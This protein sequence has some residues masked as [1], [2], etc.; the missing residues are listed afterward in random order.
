MFTPVEPHDMDFYVGLVSSS[1]LMRFIK[2]KSVNKNRS[3]YIKGCHF[4]N[5]DLP[6]HINNGE[7]SHSYLFSVIYTSDIKYKIDANNPVLL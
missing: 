1:T 3:R 5:S 4:Q 6:A 7:V 2:C